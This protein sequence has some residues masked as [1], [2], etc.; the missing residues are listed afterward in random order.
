MQKPTVLIADDVELARKLL[1]RVLDQLGCEVV[2]EVESGAQ[3]A[4][5]DRGFTKTNAASLRGDAE[6]S[7]KFSKHQ[8]CD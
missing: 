8:D 7:R 1:V 6:R 2:A 5:G 3:W 4:R